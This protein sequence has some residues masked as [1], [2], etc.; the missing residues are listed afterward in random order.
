MDR[1]H[2]TPA[3]AGVTSEEKFL[4]VIP[5]E[6]GIQDLNNHVQTIMDRL[7]SWSSSISLAF[8]K[9]CGDIPAFSIC[10]MY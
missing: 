4:L 1:H 5:A 3:F 10:L 7:V 9:G 8:I 6:A 2:W